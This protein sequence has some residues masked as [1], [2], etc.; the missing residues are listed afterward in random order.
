MNKLI[1]IGI[2]AFVLLLISISFYIG[3]ILGF[4]KSKEIDDNI[5]NELRK[6]YVKPLCLDEEVLDYYR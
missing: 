3:Y 6:K 5:L 4:K 2:I 1:I